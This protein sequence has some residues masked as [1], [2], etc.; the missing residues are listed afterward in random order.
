MT[1]GGGRS[2]FAVVNVS[3]SVLDQQIADFSLTKQINVSYISQYNQTLLK[4][5]NDNQAVFNSLNATTFLEAAG[6]ATGAAALAA[7]NNNPACGNTLYLLSNASRCFSFC[8]GNANCRLAT[9]YASVT[10]YSQ[11]ISAANPVVLSNIAAMN[12][13]IVQIVPTINSADATIKAALSALS[14][15]FGRF[16]QCAWIGKSFV[17]IRSSLCSNVGDTINV[18]WLCCGVLAVV[19]QCVPSALCNHESV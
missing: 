12:N 11:A 17:N 6:V 4:D 2:L 9:A 1:V 13:T 3:T 10:S 16:N 19:L 5:V 8:A 14:S 7:I 18:L 15:G